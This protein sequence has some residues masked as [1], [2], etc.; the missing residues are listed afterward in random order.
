MLLASAFTPPQSHARHR[1]TPL[2]PLLAKP[3]NTTTF[4]DTPLFDPNSNPWAREN[5]EAAQAVFATI[6]ITW[7]IFLAQLIVI[8]YKRNIFD[9]SRAPF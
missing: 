6:F 7:L 4:L 2:T 8:L 9:P 3:Q 1:L 5:P